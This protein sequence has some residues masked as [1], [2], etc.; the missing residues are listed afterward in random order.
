M[1]NAVTTITT[2]LDAAFTEMDAK[3]L[4]NTQAWAQGRCEALKEFKAS[5]EYQTLRRD[6]WA[7]YAKLHSL[8]GGKTW[9]SVFGNGYGTRVAEFVTKN[10]KATADRRNASIAKKLLKAGVSEVISNEFTWSPDG[11]NGIFRVA[12]DKGDQTVT[13]NTV[14]AGGYNIQCLHLRVLVHIK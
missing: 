10:C 12:T 4:D 14:Y 6:Q 2:A 8:A 7:L 3:V 5:D 9:Y 11:F 1:N 13:I